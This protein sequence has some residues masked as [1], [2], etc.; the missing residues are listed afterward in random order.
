MEVDKDLLISLLES[1]MSADYTRV[2]RVGNQ[3]AKRFAEEKDLDAAK[4]IQSLLRKRG[5]P[6]QASGFAEALPRDAGSRLPLVE[7]GNWP[8]TPVMLND[9]VGHVVTQFLEDAK[10]I[11]LLSEKGVSSRLGMLLYGPPGTGKTLLAGHIA[12]ALKRPLYIA[13][14]DSLI[15]SR[16]G[17]TAKNV[18]GVFDFIPTRNA[19]LFL[20]EMDAIAKLR[21]DRHELGEL[22]R[23]VNAVLQGLDSLTDDVVTIG[24]T[25]HPHLLDPAIWRRFPYKAEMV[26]PQVNVREDM[27][28]QFLFEGD[29]ARKADAELLARISDGLSGAD[30][31]NVS[32]A[33]R[34]RTI[35]SS[36][37]PPM[38][39]ILLAVQASRA[40]SPRLLDS[41][42]VT[43]ED[44]RALTELLSKKGNISQSEISRIVGVSRQMVHRYLKE[45]TNG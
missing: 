32:L 14:L 16:L 12:A 6:L 15:S 27:W 43:T 26:L 42:E 4:A 22:K 3:L 28:T 29:G 10:H 5:I 25:N 45:T 8:T 13:R 30:I 20:D 1:A 21:D 18:R 19:V 34:R 23:V 38:S 24:A 40:G 33:A 7:E 37:E 11:A 41:R 31:E 9:D 35:L 39:Q 2:R 36:Q 17:E 44:K